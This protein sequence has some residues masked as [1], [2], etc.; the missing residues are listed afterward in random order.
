M[1]CIFD[2]TL[3][4]LVL[5]QAPCVFNS[6]LNAY[7]VSSLSAG[8]KEQLNMVRKYAALLWN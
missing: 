8:T 1:L 4:I 2:V 6:R 3:L 5:S 7:L